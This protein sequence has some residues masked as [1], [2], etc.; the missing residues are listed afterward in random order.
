MEKMPEDAAISFDAL[1][2]PKA[3]EQVAQSIRDQVFGG[4]LSEGQRLPPERELAAQFQVSRSVVRE[5]IHTLELAGILRVQTGAGGGAFVC[6]NYDKPL[7]T[8]IGNLLAAGSISLEHLFELRLLLEPPAAEQAA[9]LKNPA[10]LQ[11]LGEV[12]DLAERHRQDSRRLRAA[13]LEFHRRLVALA[14]NPLLSALCETVLQILVESLKGRLS[15]HTSQAVLSFHKRIIKAIADGK[16][17]QARRLTEKDLEQLR[18]RY[19]SL[20][21][22]VHGGLPAEQADAV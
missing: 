11:A 13:N 3:Y 4:V 15:I 22:E 5:A 14:G 12:V 16:P 18:N 21:I 1:K 10:G 9:R 20:G 17:D 2:R 7:S 8:S 19:R 6:S